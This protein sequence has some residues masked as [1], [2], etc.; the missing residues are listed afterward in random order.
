[1]TVTRSARKSVVRVFCLYMELLIIYISLAILLGLVVF[2]HIVI[3]R[4]IDKKIE[5]QNQR[6]TACK[7]RENKI[8]KIL[9]KEQKIE[10]AEERYRT[11]SY[12]PTFKDLLNDYRS[13]YE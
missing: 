2:S 5:R 7:N 4:K 12:S 9:K 8:L 11:L 13:F 3:I 6:L 1:M 10:T